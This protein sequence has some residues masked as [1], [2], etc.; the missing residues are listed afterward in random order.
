MATKLRSLST[1]ARRW[2]SQ[3]G[4]TCTAHRRRA[5]ARARSLQ[6]SRRA[7]FP[8]A[9]SSSSPFSASSAFSSA[10]L[11]SSSSALFSTYAS[12]LPPAAAASR[13]RSVKAARDGPRGVCAGCGAPFQGTDP[14]V[15][16]FVPDSVREE[17]SAGKG[18]KGGAGRSLVC[19]RCHGL[20]YHNGRLAHEELRVS[21]PVDDAA[22]KGKGKGAAA[23]DAEGAGAGAAVVDGDTVVGGGKGGVRYLPMIPRRC[24]LCTLRTL[25]TTCWVTQHT[26]RCIGPNVCPRESLGPTYTCMVHSPVLGPT[27]RYSV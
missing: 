3:P 13:R 6:E 5:N 19:Q 25:C 2:L 9:L 21:G 12:S 26:N 22:G 8:S 16:G 23:G 11:S 18:G 7:F 10:A 20:K 4:P 17:R 15:P 1:A 24:T 27:Y 14:K